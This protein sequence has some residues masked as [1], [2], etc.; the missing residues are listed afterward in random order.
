M[1]AFRT[2]QG[3]LPA[4]RSRPLSQEAGP[5]ARRR[6]GGRGFAA[7]AAAACSVALASACSSPGPAAHPA[8][9]T[10]MAQTAAPAPHPTASAAGP[11]GAQLANGRSAGPGSAAA[12]GAPPG[13]PVPAGFQPQ[14]VT[15][16]SASTGW[17]LGI[18]PC[19]TAPCTSVVRTLDG[20][21]SWQGVP[22][23]RAPL[24]LR[25][26]RTGVRGLRFADPRNGWAYGPDLYVTHNGSATWH[27]LRPAGAVLDL[28]AAGGVVYAAVEDARGTVRLYRSPADRDAWSLA[29]GVPGDLNG[30]GLITLHGRAGWLIAGDHLYST[31]TGA[32]WHRMASPCPVFYMMASLAAHDQ[33]QLT[34]LC[35]G[36][37]A[38]GSAGKIVYSSHDGGRSF[39]RAGQAPFGGTATSLAQPGPAHIFLAT[40]SG[41]SWIYGSNDGGRTWRVALNGSGAPWNDLGFTTPAQGVVVSGIPPIGSALNMTRDGGRTWSRVDFTVGWARVLR[42]QLAVATL[43]NFKVV[44]AATRALGQSAAPAA[45]VSAAGFRRTAHG[46]KLITTKTIGR[47][48]GWSW[49]SVDVCSLT[50]TQLKPGP[51][52]AR[53]SDTIK[54]SLL[55]T[56]ALGCSATTTA[57]FG[58]GR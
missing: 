51:S 2:G 10:G 35:L 12:L 43:S 47:R 9:A 40:A 23:P 16:A 21:R 50:V 52:S 33:Q 27:R 7:L 32:R 13:G 48:G 20:G 1:N 26:E 11:A 55:M 8:G 4:E 42:R 54:A 30:L 34:L 31:T 45:S 14:S 49:Y 38:A 37:G 28:E 15:F 57:D 24:A 46:W 18:A 36:N 6:L 19:Q 44:L 41:A 5:A 53:P 17:V 25:D 39:T 3:M 56:P 58:P 22:A 29:A